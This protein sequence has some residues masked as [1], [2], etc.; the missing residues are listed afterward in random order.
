VKLY[1]AAETRL[2]RRA[3]LWLW[4]IAVSGIFAMVVVSGLVRWPF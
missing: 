1:A 2:D 3:Q 4:A